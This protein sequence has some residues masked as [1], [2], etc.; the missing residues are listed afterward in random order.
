MN[1]WLDLARG[2]LFAFSLLIMLLGLVRHVVL[3]VH[4]LVTRKGPRLARAPWATIATASLSWAVPLRHMGRRTTLFTLASFSFHLGGVLIPLFLG[5]H[6][7][8]W[9]GLLGISLP[10]LDGRVAEVLTVL[11]IVFV[12]VVAGYRSFV[13]RARDISRASDFVILLLVWLPFATGFMAAHPALDPLPWTT[14]ML[15]HVLSAEA[16]LISIPF[17][18]L[19][20]IVL[21]PFNRL[22]E[23]HWQLRPGAGEQVATALYGEEARV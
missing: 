12:P 7:V 16:L 10:S 5:A 18:K 23:V 22:S 11:T 3:Q 19:A 6:I 20:H 2:P 1:H 13:R 9:E 4:G 21:F 17:T 8:L 14:M 15:L